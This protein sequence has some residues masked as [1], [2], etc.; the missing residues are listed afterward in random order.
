[1][2]ICLFLDYKLEKTIVTLGILTLEF[3]ENSKKMCK[4]KQNKTKQKS[5]LEYT[6]KYAKF[7][8]KMKSLLIFRIK[9]ALFGWN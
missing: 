1:M 6:L 8:A 7:H 4:T 3:S 2:S 9:Y 5:N